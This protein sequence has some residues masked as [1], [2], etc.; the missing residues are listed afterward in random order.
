MSEP[1]VT[2]GSKLALRPSAGFRND[3]ISCVEDWQRRRQLGTGGR[4]P[5]GGPPKFDI[6]KVRN[7]TGGNL[8][9]GEV[10]ELSTFLLA[11][12]EQ[13]YRW[14]AGVTPDL[15][16]AAWGITIKPIPATD[17][18]DVLCVGVCIAHVLIVDESHQYANRV[19]GS[20]VLRS[21]ASGPVKIVAKPTGGTP[22]EER[23]CVVQLVDE[24]GDIVDMIEVNDTG[25]SAGELTYSTPE[26]AFAHRS[27]IRRF[28]A[29]GVT[30]ENAGDCWLLLTDEWGVAA[31]DVPA[32]NHQYYGPAKYVGIVDFDGEA[33]PT[34]VYYRGDLPTEIVE[35]YH[36]SKS[37]GDI[38]EANSGGFH[39]GKIRRRDAAGD[40]IDCGNIWIQFV[41][42]FNGH[43]TATDDGAVLACQGEY[44]GG[45]R[46]A[47]T[48]DKV[49]NPGEESET[50]DKRAVY[51]CVCDERQFLC[52]ADS[53][54]TKGSSGT[55]SL[56]NSHN[57]ADSGINRTAEALGAAIT[58]AKWSI[59][60]RV[61]GVWYVS[62]WEC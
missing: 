18:D 33:L 25:K 5:T 1:R 12:L 61:A 60:S 43:D 36:D 50:H 17:I 28:T 2:A 21:A 7:N 54:I 34:Y 19:S 16:H 52:K 38:V 59:Y 8:R 55:I 15:T 13:E 22:P 30:F 26:R 46:Y 53:S 49:T 45:A 51:V 35:V 57:K 37:T 23:E 24:T 11:T 56:Y 47:N 9:R 40:Y 14:F 3:T 58:S 62:P 10:V 41:E 39:P 32:V 6:V 27:K 29:T 31:G 20:T 48:W 42:G 44:Y 4:K